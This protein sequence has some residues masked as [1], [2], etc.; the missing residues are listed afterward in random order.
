MARRNLVFKAGPEA[1]DSIRRHGFAP[2]RIGT[3]VGASGGAKW[4]ML[5]QLDRVI[6]ENLVP[7][8]AGPVHLIGTSIGAWRFACYAS[9]DPFSAI[10]SFEK[11]YIEQTYS[12][13]PDRD[14]IS[15]V[16]RDMLDRIAGNGGVADIVGHPTL[17]T[18]I[19]TVR[20]RHLTASDHKALLVP[21][22]TG[23]VA[24]N[25]VSRR[26]LGLF[27]DRGLF[28]DVRD[29]PPFYNVEGFPLCRIPLSERNFMD[30]VTASGSIPLVL[31]GIRNIEG[32]PAGT[33]RDGGII[34]YHLDFPAADADRIA[35]YPHFFNWFKPG[36]F[37]RQL[38]WRKL[39]DAALDRTVVI[40]PSD[41]FI[42]G[43]PHAKVPNRQDF[44]DF[45]AEDRIAMWR[46]VVSRCE[47]LADE[48][49]E[50]LE[51]DLLPERLQVIQ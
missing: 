5:S 25:L 20:C 18:H 46:T 24:A 40:C 50:V 35:L 9:R 32:A 7:R 34:D 8:M 26:L 31:N 22:L 45:A 30:A 44:V 38:P 3:L 33:Y 17:R 1:F 41:E 12:E 16:G 19:I 48:L 27:F 28:H 21:G 42:A 51:R 43:L 4:L 15:R 39:S 10:E 11:M 23:A 13:K 37:D 47:E 49:T 14:E 6:L 2:E 36:W 29:L